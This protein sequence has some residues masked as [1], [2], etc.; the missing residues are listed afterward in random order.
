MIV[1]AAMTA[2][3]VMQVGEGAPLG[4]KEEGIILI[5]LSKEAV[6]LKKTIIIDLFMLP[7]P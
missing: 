6:M 7:P 1:L 2:A 5:T 4:S 3:M